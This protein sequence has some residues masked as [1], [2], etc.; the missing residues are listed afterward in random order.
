MNR[1]ADPAVNEPN[2]HIHL[3]GH[4]WPEYRRVLLLVS[5]LTFVA[6]KAW[7]DSNFGKSDQKMASSCTK[8]FREFSLK[9]FQDGGPDYDLA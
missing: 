6:P 3:V 2:F 7:I 8:Q 4:F 1:P 9:C 5:I